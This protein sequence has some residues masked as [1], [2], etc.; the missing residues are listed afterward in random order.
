MRLVVLAILM[1]LTAQFV[2]VA[3][4][5]AWGAESDTLELYDATADRMYQAEPV[6][7]SDAAWKK[8]LTAEQFHVARKHGTE[9]PFSNEYWDNH[10]EGLYRCIC[11]DTDLFLSEAKFDSGTGWPSF[12]APVD[13]ANVGNESDRSFGM[14]RTEVHCRRCGA[15]LGHVFNDGPQPTALRYCINSAAL[16]FVPEAEQKPHKTAQ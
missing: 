13:E 8:T 16:D 6:A 14:T 4:H 15:H 3:G 11:C 1:I 7:K 12:T 2:L 9:R 5:R 10:A